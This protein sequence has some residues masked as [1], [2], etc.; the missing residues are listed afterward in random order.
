M[1]GPL[2][3][4]QR[5]RLDSQ[6]AQQISGR[7][8]AVSPIRVQPLR[9]GV[10]SPGLAAHLGIHDMFV[11]AGMPDRQ[12]RAVPVGDDVVLAAPFPA[13]LVFSAAPTARTLR[14]S[15]AARDQSIRRQRSNPPE[16]SCAA[17]PRLPPPAIVALLADLPDIF[18]GNTGGNATSWRCVRRL[19]TIPTRKLACTQTTCQI[20]RTSP[21]ASRIS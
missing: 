16:V 21:G 19:S 11:G 3:M 17:D 20:Q 7:L 13:I 6:P 5:I 10:R 14:L 12:G 9:A 2:L 18:S 4:P 8:G 1:S 15:I